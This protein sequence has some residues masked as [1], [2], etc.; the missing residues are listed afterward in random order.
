MPSDEEQ[1]TSGQPQAAPSFKNDI[2]PLFR[3]VD[4]AHMQPMGVLLNDYAFMSMPANA[5]N[6]YSYLTGNNHPR[7]PLGGPYW[8]SAQLALFDRWMTT[9]YKP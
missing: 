8:S 3:Q 1:K 4:I 7:M 2:L 9:G 6:V 5:Q